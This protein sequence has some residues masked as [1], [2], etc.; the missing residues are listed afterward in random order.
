MECNAF[1]VGRGLP[2]LDFVQRRLQMLGKRITMNMR[3][4]LAQK[5]VVR[6][7]EKIPDSRDE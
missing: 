6:S 2:N 7:V 4:R 3:R 1:G 5:R